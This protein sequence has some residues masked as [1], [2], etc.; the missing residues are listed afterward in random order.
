MNELK[1]DEKIKILAKFFTGEK[2]KDDPHIEIL[3]TLQDIWDRIYKENRVKK[4]F[5]AART[6]ANEYIL[7]YVLK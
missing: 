1:F 4:S 6:L 2:Y 7:F 3:F 5:G